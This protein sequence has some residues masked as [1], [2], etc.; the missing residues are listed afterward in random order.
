M[1]DELGVNPE[2]LRGW[3]RQARIDAG[4]R[5]GT[6]TEG[7]RRIKEL[8]KE[9]RELRRAN[10]ILRSAS[11]ILLW[12][13]VSAHR[14]DLRLHRGPEGGVRGRADLHRPDR[15]RVQDRPVHLLRRPVP[16]ALEEVG[17]RRRRGG[18]RIL[19]LRAEP[20]N[21][22]LGSRKTWRLLNTRQEGPGV[23]RCTV[24]RRMRAL[25][26][27][28][29]GPGRTVRATGP[30]EGDRAP[31]GLLRRDSRRHRPEPQMGGRLHL[32][33]DLVGVLVARRSSWTCSPAGSSAGPPARARGTDNAGSALEHAIQ[34]RKERGGADL[35]G[36]VHHCDRGSKSPVHRLHRTTR[37]RGDPGPPPE[38]W[39]PPTTTPPPRPSTSPTSAS[40]SGATAP[41]RDAPTSRPRPPDG[42]TGTTAPAPTSPTTTTS[43][44]QPSNTATITT[45]P[46]PHPPP[47]NQPSTK[48]GTIHECRVEASW[49]SGQGA[50]LAPRCLAPTSSRADGNGPCRKWT[51]RSCASAGLERRRLRATSKNRTHPYVRQCN[52]GSAGGVL[53]L[54]LTIDKP[55][56]P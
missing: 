7:A 42:W 32:R 49:F 37:P 36:L 41:G 48:P 47:Y 10:A 53:T 13:S 43:H 35:E 56:H 38:P 8:E 21:A 39:A 40:S 19:A 1:G 9:V 2:T 31:T 30:A 15:V 26:L 54:R 52:G 5:P 45:T 50:S 29:A 44:P 33:A 16:P 24:E 51:G 4:D 23:A 20:F 28:G 11:A 55:T 46:P 27:T 18:G 3:V 12:Q 22:A 17:V 14:A 25:G 6:T 34:A